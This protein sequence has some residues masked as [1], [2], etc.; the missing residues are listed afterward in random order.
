MTFSLKSEWTDFSHRVTLSCK[1]TWK[2]IFIPDI[3]VSAKNGRKKDIGR[4]LKV[5]TIVIMSSVSA[6]E[7]HSRSR[8][9]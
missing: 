3:H 1:G 5:S 6:D 9:P 4:H 8:I 7:E 2:R